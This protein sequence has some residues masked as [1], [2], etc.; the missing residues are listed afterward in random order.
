MQK[1]TKSLLLLLM[2]ATSIIV[3]FFVIP[4]F[5]I[6]L[7]SFTGAKTGLAPQ[8]FSL[9][10]F[11][12]FFTDEYYISVCFFTFRLSFWVTL[13]TL[14]I[15][16]PLSYYIVRIVKSKFYRRIFY[17]LIVAPLFTSSIVRA[18]AWM[19]ILGRTGLVNKLLVSLHLVDSP[20]RLLFNQIGVVIGL[21]YILSPF[22][23]LTIATVLQNIDRSLEEAA[24]DLGA[25]KLVTFL[26]VTLPL[27]IPGVVAGSLI[28]FTLTVSAYVTPA[29]LG[30]KKVQVLP[31]LIYEQYM[32]TFDW[33]FGSALAIVL[34]VATLIL[35]IIYT[36]FSEQKYAILEKN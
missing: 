4:L 16:Y 32:L 8:S 2:P 23:I 21:V 33:A 34:L 30:G 1:K 25:S 13:I 29:V 28:V 22:M 14:L 7:A 31:M 3:G 26:K 36:R 5:L 27:S 9:R 12:K 35:I 19:V 24:E 11:I 20:V 17:I 6:G 15:G 10:N 18:F